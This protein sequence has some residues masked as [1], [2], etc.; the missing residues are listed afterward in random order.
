MDHSDVKVGKIC[1]TYL[2]GKWVDTLK[3]DDL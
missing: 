2:A 1:F 3:S